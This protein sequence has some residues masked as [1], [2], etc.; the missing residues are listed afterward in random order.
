M[1]PFCHRSV[2]YL[3]GR[4]G[5]C[6]AELFTTLLASVSILVLGVLNILSVTALH[7]SPP[8]RPI[9]CCFDLPNP[10]LFKNFP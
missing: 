8:R 6:V 9:S 4:G 1:P 3:K 7:L 2:I 5:N 10:T